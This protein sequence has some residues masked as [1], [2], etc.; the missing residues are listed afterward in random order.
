MTRTGKAFRETKETR[1]EAA[2]E[3]DGTG[4]CDV[5]TGH[6]F[7]DHMINTLAKHSLV[8]IVVKAT[9]DLRH[10]I[11]EDTAIVL[12]MAFDKALGDRTGIKRFGHAIVPMDESLALAA[13]DLVKRPKPFIDLKTRLEI[14]EDIPMTEIIH[15][16]ETF[17]TSLNATIHVEILKGL[18]DHHKTE[19]A[20][21]A[22]A[23]ALKQAIQPEPRTKGPPSTKATM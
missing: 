8:D 9:G 13:V 7:L 1:I 5:S 3:L 20:F 15:F 10:H 4:L 19:A 21:K 6:R 12:G 2:V 23:Q 11:V 16:L 18:D 22:L 17:T 14:I